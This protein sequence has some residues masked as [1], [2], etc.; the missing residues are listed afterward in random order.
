ME[1]IVVSIYML[2]LALLM[3]GW[4]VFF[5]RFYA[6]QLPEEISENRSELNVFNSLNLIACNDP[7]KNNQEIDEDQS[8]IDDIDGT[9]L[10]LYTI[11]YSWF[12]S[13]SIHHM[14]QY[15]RFQV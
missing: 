12:P 8:S 7:E 3:S 6:K 15:G 2:S 10:Y 13:R 1:G 4:L 14:Q 11:V 5:K 9:I